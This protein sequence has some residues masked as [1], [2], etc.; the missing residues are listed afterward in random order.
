MA[1]HSST[2][3]WKIPWTEEPGRPQ[4]MRLL[5][6]RHDWMPSPSLFT[7]HF[8]AAEKEMNPLQCSCLKNPRAGGAWLLP[9][10]GSHRVGHDW[11]NLAAAAVAKFTM[12]YILYYTILYY[13]IY[14]ILLYYIIPYQTIL[15]YG[16][17]FFTPQKYQ[18]NS[19]LIWY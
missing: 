14:L 1:T 10:M 5:R 17:C 3:V 13:T 18:F 2:L 11:N 12:V 6:V 9:S 7:F 15:L 16:K 19:H 4:S 8:H